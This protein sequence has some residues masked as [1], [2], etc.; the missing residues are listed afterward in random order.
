LR[1]LAPKSSRKI[2]AAKLPEREAAVSAV[3][4]SAGGTASTWAPAEA[5]F[6]CFTRS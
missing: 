6:F 3:T 1:G 5:G 2:A 4:P